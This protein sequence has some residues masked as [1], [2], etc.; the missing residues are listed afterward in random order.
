MDMKI[1]E[2]DRGEIT[3]ALELTL[4]VFMEFEA[5]DYSQE[6]I[7]EFRD[8]LKDHGRIEKLQFF[9]AFSQEGLLVGTFAMRQGHVSLLFVKKAFHRRGIAKNLFLHVLEQI[10]SEVIT[11]NSSPYALEV[12]EKL[13]FTAVN[14]EQLIN[15][16]RYTPMVYAGK[17]S[18]VRK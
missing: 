17:A 11:V 13:G 4:E 3:A 5:P 12:Y 18:S 10:K 2:L 6:G 7:D 9:G 15:G 8:F 1:R 16:I 14:S